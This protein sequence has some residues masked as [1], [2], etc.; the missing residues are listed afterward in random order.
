[1]AQL[2]ENLARGRIKKEFVLGYRLI[3][4]INSSIKSRTKKLSVLTF[5][6]HF[7]L[8]QRRV[9]ISKCTHLQLNIGQTPVRPTL[10]SNQKGGTRP[11]AC[12][13]D[14]I[15]WPSLGCAGLLITG[16]WYKG[17]SEGASQIFCFLIQNN[18]HGTGWIGLEK[19]NSF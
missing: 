15:N 4:Q 10:S 2:Q 3:T 12:D 19:I 1:M 16:G 9:V 14:L 8:P 7:W 6:Q 5:R 18:T 13:T 17:P 11:P